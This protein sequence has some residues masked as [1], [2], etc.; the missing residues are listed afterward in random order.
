MPWWP[1]DDTVVCP[2][3]S[4]PLSEGKH[5]VKQ[6]MQPTQGLQTKF[7]VFVEIRLI[8]LYVCN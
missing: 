5:S 8:A 4:S 6:Y 3:A 1:T 7:T 2:V